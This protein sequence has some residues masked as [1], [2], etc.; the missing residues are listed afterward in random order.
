MKKVVIITRDFPPYEGRGNVMRMVK[1]AKYLPR[2]GW[3]PFVLCEKKDGTTDSTLLKELPPEV[4]I[5][6]VEADTPQKKKNRYKK[7]LKESSNLTWRQMI[8]Y[9][10]YRSVL[11]NLYAFYRNYFMAPDESL[12]WAREAAK[13]AAQLH[14][15]QRFDAVLTSGP[16]FSTFV[17]G[18]Q[19]KKELGLPWVVDFRDGWVGNPYFVRKF[20]CFIRWKN[21]R[22]E[23]EA[24]QLADRVL[25]VTDPMVEIYR[26]RY[27][28]QS[29]KM[30]LLTNGFDPDDF[31][32]IEPKNEPRPFLKLVYSGTISGRRSPYYFFEGLRMALHK[33]PSLKNKIRVHFIGKFNYQQEIPEEVKR[34]LEMEG[35]VNHQDALN[36]MSDADL[37]LFMNNPDLGGR[38]VMTGKIF[39]YLALNKPVFAI[40]NSCA[41]TDLM[42]DFDIGYF[43]RFDDPV[44]IRDKL[45]EIVRDWKEGKLRQIEDRRTVARF[46]RKNLTEKL[47]SILNEISE[48]KN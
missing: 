27:P 13:Q 38:T 1:F 21:R 40:S 19:L 31:R 47:A 22:L 36:R 5:I 18:I 48:G 14:R 29:N 26:R 16:P 41:A 44:D 15:E 35:Q 7:Y 32:G 3:Q 12:P 34:V 39:E 6:E 24:V 42:A 8:G 30:R 33:N 20:G 23:Q 45:L 10:L 11:Y 9:L 28:A 17:A 25:L 4:K 37:L 2:F 46:E 43:A